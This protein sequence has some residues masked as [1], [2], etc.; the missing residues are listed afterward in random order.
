MFAFTKP[1]QAPKPRQN[2]YDFRLPR[3]GRDFDC[4]FRADRHIGFTADAEFRE[5]CGS[6][7]LH[8]KWVAGV[9]LSPRRKPRGFARNSLQSRPT[10]PT[11]QRSATTPFREHAV[12]CFFVTFCFERLGIVCENALLHSAAIWNATVFG[13]LRR[14]REVR[15]QRSWQSDVLQG[16][17]FIEFTNS[18][19]ISCD[20]WRLFTGIAPEFAL[21]APLNQDSQ[22]DTRC[23]RFFS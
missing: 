17:V 9:G 15:L 19:E 8:L 16:V 5:G 10:S 1:T 14:F 20:Y 13:D 18:S 2:S 7:L 3:T 6:R 21:L 12:S 23:P 22:R 4:A 11:S